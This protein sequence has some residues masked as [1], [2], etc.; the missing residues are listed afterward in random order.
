M[1]I[2][3]HGFGVRKDSRGMFDDLSEAINQPSI[4]FDYNQV[5]ESGNS[6]TVVSLFEQAKILEN[7]A[8]QQTKSFNLICHSA[9][10]MVAALADFKTPPKN[11]LFLAPMTTTN[12][13][14]FMQTFRDRTEGEMNRH[15]TSI[16]RRADG[17]LTYVEPSFWD[18]LDQISSAEEEYINLAKRTRLSLIIAGEDD[19]V[20]K[21]N[22]K[23]L[24]D[25]TVSYQVIAGANHNFSNHT[26]KLLISQVKQWAN[27]SVS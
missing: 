23:T 17:S 8:N 16:I 15:A 10:C 25:L 7:I 1:I 6:I 14:K 11:I 9:G 19:K 3:S 27:Q 20:G 5:D 24:K 21:A 4:K 2:F 12:S 18:S 26:R 22:F 13:E